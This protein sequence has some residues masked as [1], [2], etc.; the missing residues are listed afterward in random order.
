MLI[1]DEGENIIAGET[2]SYRCQ[3]IFSG[4]QLWSG[5]V[6]GLTVSIHELA[7]FARSMVC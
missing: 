5:G 1:L 3:S 4:F 2:P 7:G 6:G